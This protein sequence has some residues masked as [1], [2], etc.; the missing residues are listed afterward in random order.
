[1]YDF[2]YVQWNQISSA[3]ET[4]VGGGG[5]GVLKFHVIWKKISLP[6]GLINHSVKIL[7]LQ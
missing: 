3:I 6:K 5:M 4:W 7:Y 1:M 2:M